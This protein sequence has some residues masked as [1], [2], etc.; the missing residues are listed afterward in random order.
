M[1]LRLFLVGV[2]AS[3]ALDLPS[4]GVNQS[5]WRT[6]RSWLDAKLTGPATPSR[7]VVVAE[8]KAPETEILFDTIAQVATVGQDRPVGALDLDFPFSPVVLIET[9]APSVLALPGRVEAAALAVVETPVTIP[10]A[11]SDPVSTPMPMP[12]PAPE[13]ADSALI[14]EELSAFNPALEP[15]PVEIASIPDSIVDP[16]ASFRTIVGQMASV[17]AADVP[18][19]PAATEMRPLIA[20]A[21]IPPPP[22]PEASVVAGF[23]DEED[24][25]DEILP[26]LAYYLN[27][28]AEGL[29]PIEMPAAAEV[30]EAPAE[31]V[32]SEEEARPNRE[33][34]LAHAVQ[35]TG[36]A[37]QAWASLLVQRPAAGAIQR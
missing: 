36:Q 20:K 29:T 23:E 25:E 24:L 14:A 17:F 7:V 22:A 2:V 31:L 13:I 10:T 34:R 28:A 12:T 21:E 19:A 33:N 6:G 1:A 32:T 30:A 16:D 8:P 9:P 3:L 35:L 26:G 15:M 37:M 27:R 4:G 11:V 5:N 18:A